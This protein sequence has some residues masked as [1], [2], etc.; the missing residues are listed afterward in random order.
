MVPRCT[1]VLNRLQLIVHQIGKREAQLGLLNN[2]CNDKVL[3]NS[4]ILSS[5]KPRVG[6]QF[7]Y[8]DLEKR[9]VHILTDARHELIQKCAIVE[10]RRDI[11]HLKLR[12]NKLIKDRKIQTD[13]QESIRLEQSKIKIEH[14]KKHQKKLNFHHNQMLDRK[15]LS[16]NTCVRNQKQKQHVVKSQLQKRLQ[17]KAYKERVRI[18]K[19][20][21]IKTHV[22]TIKLNKVK[23]FS[24][25]DIPNIVYLYLDKGLGF[26]E[27]KIGNIEDIKFDAKDFLRKLGWKIHFKN[28]KPQL[29]D[30]VDEQ[31][32]DDAHPSLRIPSRNHPP[33]D[34]MPALFNEIRSKLLG[35]LSTFETTKPPSNL[36]PAEQRGKAWITKEVKEQRLFVTKADKGGAIL[37][38]NFEDAFQAVKKEMEDE[39]KFEVLNV[40]P[41]VHMENTQKNIVSIV[42]EC[43]KG[44]IITEKDR[45]LITGITNNGGKKHSHVFSPVMP[46]PY[47]L[48]KI[49]K[50]STEEIE[51]KVIPPL[52]LVH[53]TC[54]GPLYR[55]EKWCSP[56]LTSLSK[57]YCGDE[58]IQDTPALIEAIETVNSVHGSGEKCLLFTLDVVALYPSICK[59]MALKAM[60]H[61]MEA[62]SF[63]NDDIKK[64]VRKFSE[65]ILNESFVVFENK[66]YRG[67]KG[68]PTGNCISR[69]VAD[70]SMHWLLFV[71]LKIQNWK[72]WK[73]IK[74][75]KRY[76]DD[77]FG[78]WKGTVR[79]FH[80]FV[81]E[82]NE[83]AKAYGIQFADAQIDDSVHNLDITI[84]ND[85]DGNM[86]Y[87][88]FRKETDARQFLNTQSFHP[89]DVFKSVAFSQMLRVISRNSTDETTVRDIAELKNDLIKCGHQ[90]EKL[91][92]IEPLAVHRVMTKYVRQNSPITNDDKNDHPENLVFTTT[93][94]KEVKQL[95][96]FVRKLEPD[97]KRILG[98][99]RIIFALKKNQSIQQKVVKNRGLSLGEN[100]PMA[101]IFA[102][103][104]SQACGSKGCETCPLLFNLQ[105]DIFVNGLK[106]IL[107]KSLNC[108][109][110]GIIYLAQCLICQAKKV[111]LAKELNTSEG[112]VL[113]EDS[114][115]GQTIN[116][117]HIRMNGHRD[118]FKKNNKG[119]FTKCRKSAL[120]W[121]CHEEHPDQCDLKM[122]KI[123]FIRACRSID[124]D[125][126]EN[127][128][129]SKFRTD[130]IGLNR[131]K[132]VR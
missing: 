47:P 106:V 32:V 102:A 15:V 4:K 42:K 40:T 84:Y 132:V 18:K 56:C 5:L 17:N 66:V 23:N 96:L 71:C 72:W 98:E 73:L 101:P 81:K 99:V 6:N 28:N 54:Q 21:W 95:K 51:Q 83:K 129:I 88:L 44:G 7:S 87:C 123:G 2:I 115:L 67:K 90:E 48:F 92:M 104:V 127:R 34:K 110:K 61:A 91:E 100:N 22:E 103:K 80:L 55:L 111:D 116:E 35:F 33:P 108:K 131:I 1:D 126:E 24:D 62:D 65:F 69:Q 9:K 29:E 122:F 63:E 3:L 97:I 41:E 38:L 89:E 39:R 114:Y 59:D 118:C 76:I 14:E 113:V 8:K 105:N 43:E 60:D 50:C 117:G 78:R 20:E 124:L 70:I 74:F 16:S 45:L 26:V 128:L 27:S 130:V 52:R 120:S 11:D 93:Y 107:D 68:I 121:H 25:K 125:R 112:N 19:N 86:Q 10:A 31:V 75:W 53:S 82:L 94:F 46:Y 109:S 57:N 64:A 58:F 77:I 119:E 37:I 36:T 30:D 85:D 12:F 79:Q 13:V 49:H